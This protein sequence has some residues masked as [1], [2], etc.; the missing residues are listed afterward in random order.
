MVSV[1]L[2]VA[3]D[4]KGTLTTYKLITNTYTWLL[5]FALSCVKSSMNIPCNNCSWGPTCSRS[6]Q[7]HIKAFPPTPSLLAEYQWQISGHSPLQNTCNFFVLTVLIFLFVKNY[8]YC[9][10]FCTT[11]HTEFNIFLVRLFRIIDQRFE[12][13]S[14]FV[15]GDFNFRLDAKSVVEVGSSSFIW[16]TI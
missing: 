10:A 9:F 16:T 15:F 4:W 12:R 3:W 6:A 8:K 13:V 11:E 14:Y 7:R 2:F 5:S 1:N